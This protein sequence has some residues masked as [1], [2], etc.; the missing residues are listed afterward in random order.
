MFATIK[1]R[2][3]LLA[4]EFGY[5]AGYAGS[6]I[7][8]PEPAQAEIA[9]VKAGAVDITPMLTDEQVEEIAD[10]C[11][12]WVIDQREA[13]MEDRRDRERDECE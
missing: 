2:G 9:A 3:V 4:C 6:R 11:V 8:P 10:A 1:Y 12:E 13:A 5:Y 7:D